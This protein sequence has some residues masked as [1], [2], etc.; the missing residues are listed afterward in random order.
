MGTETVTDLPL[1]TRNYTN[2]LAMSAGANAAVSNATSLGKA[3]TLIAVNGAGFGQN[4]NYL[5]DGVSLS[6]WYKL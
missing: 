1:N 6:N 2:L 3:S 4:N 5:Q